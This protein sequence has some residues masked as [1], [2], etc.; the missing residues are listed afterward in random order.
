[1]AFATKYRNEFTDE[2]G[3]TWM[4]EI[5]Q[6][7]FASTVTN[8]T[9]TGSPLSIEWYGDDDIYRDYIKG[10]KLTL[11]VEAPSDL[12]LSDLFTSENLEYKVK[13][14]KG[15]QLLLNLENASY[16]TYVTSGARIISAI[17]AGAAE[18]LSTHTIPITDG[19][20]VYVSVN[21]SYS[22]SA[23]VVYL[24]DALLASNQVN[25]SNGDNFIT[26]TP[27]ATTD[28][29]IHFAVT[30]ATNFTTSEIFVIQYT[31]F[32]NGFI[33]ANSY[34]EPYD[35]LPYSIGI[36]ATD[37]LGILK[38]YDF[39]DLTYTGR[40][41]LA[42]VIFD[43]LSTIGVTGFAEYIN[44]YENQIFDTPD[45][46]PLDQ[47]KID[48]DVFS[49]LTLY[50]ALGEMLKIFNAFIRQDNGVMS[51]FNIEELK[52]ENITGRLF[53]TATAHT[54][55]TKA[56][57]Q[58]IDRPTNISTFKDYNGGTRMKI[59][60]AKKISI[61]QDYGYKESWIENYNFDTD[62]TYKESGYWE[63]EGWTRNGGCLLL[64]PN[65]V[66]E[67]E[68]IVLFD[69]NAYPTLTK[70]ISQSFAPNSIST[71]DILVFSIDY[72]L[73]NIGLA[74]VGGNEIYIKV[75]ADGANKWL[76]GVND[77]YAD[78]DSSDNKFILTVDAPVGTTGWLNY[79]CRVTGL[80]VDGPYTISVFATDDSAPNV[81]L[82]VKNI[83][84]YSTGDT[85]IPYRTKNYAWP[86]GF[87]TKW[88]HTLKYYDKTEVVVK[89]YEKTNSI[90]GE[91][92]EK[93]AM[94]GDVADS[95][96][97]NILEQFAGA[98]SVLAVTYQKRVDTITL[99]GTSGQADVG[100]NGLSYSCVFNTTLSQTATDYY[101]AH[102]NDYIGVDI[103]LT[104]DNENLVF[105]S[106]AN[107]L[108]FDPAAFITPDL[109]NL[110]GTVDLTTPAYVTAEEPSAS[111][112]SAGSYLYDD[113][114]DIITDDGLAIIDLDYGSPEADPLIEL[115]AIE[116]QTQYGRSKQ[117]I[118][119]PLRETDRD[120][121]FDINGHL[122]DVQNE[123]NGSPCTFVVA[124]AGYN[125]R[126]REYNL[127]L[128]EII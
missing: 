104:A 47:I 82:A 62:R 100:C 96:I 128:T 78:W 69:H 43:I 42:K 13:V 55:V 112:N 102:V 9:G 30:G 8:L 48:T 27:T 21:V 75:K 80:D 85:V 52:G 99:T 41:T 49:K 124:R 118:D 94:L 16:D 108:E 59:P 22:G 92:I 71:S 7:G 40:E 37:S 127:V 53:S 45:D 107:G 113:S 76:Y 106:R 109:G 64:P 88:K 117:V 15:V 31:N 18:S 50:D 14:S 32:W 91:I 72:L 38:D 44:S 56:A 46:S 36:S 2:L 121:F 66:N 83:Q 68:G 65:T 111:W 81:H 98:L 63:A 3:M 70:Y 95:G 11:N 33:V 67:N 35:G 79:K 120:T 103:D 87:L 126:E 29:Y 10:S 122:Q 23:P 123:Y 86:F 90:A 54:S 105:T 1:L 61:N 60:G 89:P 26:L 20:P 4:T 58:S 28:A 57:N 6:D 74:D 77:D 119:L 101:N 97:D 115:A 39:S 110:D 93:N 25:L 125:I 34:S 51:I 17:S 73:Y 116:L 12:G 114:E 5:Q 24:A 19:V 84:F